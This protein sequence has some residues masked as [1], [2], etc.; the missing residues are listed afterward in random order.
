[1]SMKY[2]IFAYKEEYKKLFAEYPQLEKFLMA[3]KIEDEYMVSLKNS[4]FEKLS[5]LND[6]I[7]KQLG[8]RCD[9]QR[10]ENLHKL[11]NQLTGE[12]MTLEVDENRIYIHSA[13]KNNIFFYIIYQKLKSYVII[14]EK[15]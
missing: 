15:L 13:N 12:V 3:E 7:F 14:E 11:N 1:M 10:Q 6:V 4:C 2:T 5:F 9:Y 8:T